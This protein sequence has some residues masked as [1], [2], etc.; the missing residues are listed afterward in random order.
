MGDR[1][2]SRCAECGEPLDEDMKCRNCDAS[3]N[4]PFSEE[5]SKEELKSIMEWLSGATDTLSFDREREVSESPPAKVIENEDYASELRAKLSEA[6]AKIRKMQIELETYEAIA[7][8]AAQ[9]EIVESLSQALKAKQEAEQRLQEAEKLLNEMREEIGSREVKIRE[10]EEELKR[11][12]QEAVNREAELSRREQLMQEEMQ[13]LQAM[14]DELG[15]A[16]EIEMKKAL[17]ELREQIRVKEEKMREMQDYLRRKEEEIQVREKA[18]I[19]KE[20]DAFEEVTLAELKQERVKTGIRQLDNL[21]MGGLPLGSQVMIYGPPFIGKEVAVN[22]FAAEAVKKGVPLIWITTDRTV[23]QIREE[24]AFVVSNLEVYEEKGLIR[25]IDLYS[26]SVGD[27]EDTPNVSIVRDFSDT[28]IV[29]KLMSEYLES[30]KETVKSR[31]YRVVFRTVSALTAVMEMKDM[32]KML[33]SFVARRKRDKAVTFYCVDKGLIE[34]EVLNIASMMDGVIEFSS[35]AQGNSL[36]IKG[37]TKTA[38]T[39]K[40]SYTFTR[41]GL[42]IGS[43]T[44]GRV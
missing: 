30:I 12:Q 27:I 25:Y 14:K 8:A 29:E 15:S 43:F 32:L 6:E 31:G 41:Q 2:D 40:V 35:D 10:L 20:L 44:I 3:G 16:N 7:N 26:G 9:K 34:Q 18:V 28:E 1:Q 5:E 24:M 13:K 39:D 42:T 38:T 21:L 17:E 36:A 22:Q 33:R 23:D 11:I 19:E 37:I 4:M